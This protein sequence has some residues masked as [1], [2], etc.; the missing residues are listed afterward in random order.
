M[1]QQLLWGISSSW[2]SLGLNRRIAAGAAACCVVTG[3]VI[4]RVLG[5]QRSLRYS[6]PLEHD[7]NGEDDDGLVFVD[8]LE[9]N[10]NCATR[11]IEQELA[12]VSSVASTLENPAEGADKLID[13]DVFSFRL[14]LLEERITKL[15]IRIDAVECG[16]RA[17]WREK[18]K[19]W[20]LACNAASGRLRLLHPAACADLE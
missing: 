16:D 10:F 4:W 14:R 7:E 19:E 3:L 12:D 11:S 2:G 15:L 9:H 20:V 17:D 1:A 6:S 18:R 5:R 8:T 13:D